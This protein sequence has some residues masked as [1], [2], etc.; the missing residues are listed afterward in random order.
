MDSDSSWRGASGPLRP[1]DSSGLGERKS[2]GNVSGIALTI[3]LIVRSFLD[4][5]VFSP[6][7]TGACDPWLVWK[8]LYR[9]RLETL[10][11]RCYH[12]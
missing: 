8:F 7:A 6:S 4:S 3:S 1:E 10:S 11:H 2:L 12:H 5:R 9:R